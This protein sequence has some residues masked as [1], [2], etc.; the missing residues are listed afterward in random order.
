MLNI[1]SLYSGPAKPQNQRLKSENEPNENEIFDE[2]RSMEMCD[3]S[4]CVEANRRKPNETHFSHFSLFLPFFVSLKVESIKKIDSTVFLAFDFEE[5]YGL[6][7]NYIFICPSEPRNGKTVN[8]CVMSREDF[9]SQSR[10]A[11]T[12]NPDTKFPVRIAQLTRF[13]DIFDCKSLFGYGVVCHMRNL[14]FELATIPIAFCLDL[15]VGDF[16]TWADHAQN[17]ESRTTQA[18]RR[19]SKTEEGKWRFTLEICRIILRCISKKLHTHCK[20]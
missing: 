17:D 9:S 6:R 14:I 20:Q 2:M 19:E 13:R 7:I 16:A 8:C 11:L 18:D 15:N 3:V 1:T 4:G 5:C 12:D 10:W